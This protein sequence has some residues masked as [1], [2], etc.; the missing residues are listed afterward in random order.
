MPG[1]ESILG[2]FLKGYGQTKF[3]SRLDEREKEKDALLKENLKI[4]QQGLKLRQ[5]QE[6]RQAKLEDYVMSALGQSSEPQNYVE[7][8]PGGQEMPAYGEGMQGGGVTEMMARLQN[9]PDLLMKM[10]MAG[11]KLGELADFVQDRIEFDAL[12]KQRERRNQFTES[13][14]LTEDFE[15]N[16]VPMRRY[17]TKY[18]RQQVGPAFPTGGKKPMVA[19]S[20]G[21][22]AMVEQ[23]A[24]DLQLAKNIIL[25]ENGEPRKD[26]LLQMAVGKAG[27][28]WT[29]GRE[30]KAYLLNAMEGKIRI[31]S[32]AA[33]PDPEIVRLSLRFMPS[34]FDTPELAKNKLLR[35]EEYL[36]G[37]IEKLDPNKIYSKDTLIVETEKG[38]FAWTPKKAKSTLP[39]S[40]RKRL[41]Q[42]V[43]TEFG[44]GQVWTLQNGE[45]VRIK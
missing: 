11:G 39:Q 7:Q 44:N 5:L 1:I 8:K 14:L 12:Q 27:M 3:Q 42:G 33:V 37:V 40:A 19:E 20:A 41:K 17:V 38:Q 30:A 29:K 13:E 26:I 31:E 2:G 10:A 45:P 43:H 9:D 23:G 21:K 18:G 24:S 4:Q 6:E 34:I 16:G 28:P 15:Q 22:L 32:G 36:N 35:L 25:D